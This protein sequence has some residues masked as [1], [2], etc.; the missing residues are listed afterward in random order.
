MSNNPSKNP[1]QQTSGTYQWSNNEQRREYHGIS[2]FLMMNKY[3][4]IL[5]LDRLK[6]GSKI[7]NYSDIWP[8]IGTFL[9][10]LLVLVTTDCKDILGLPSSEWQAIFIIALFASFGMVIYTLCRAIIHRK[11]RAKTPEEE[12]EQIIAQMA[13]DREKIGK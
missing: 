13:S 8:W 1:N 6:K 9:A 11:E 2:E 7:P 12:V 5:V 10:F 4:L 3:H